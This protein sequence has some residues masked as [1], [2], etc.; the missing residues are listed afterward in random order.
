M[1]LVI[2]TNVLM[3]ALIKDA[4]T[5]K[6]IIE[7]AIEFYAPEVIKD[8]IFKYKELILKK[9]KSSEKDCIELFQHLFKHVELIPND[10]IL[11]KVAKAKEIMYGVDPNDVLFIAAALS[12]DYDGI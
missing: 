6:I 5:R 2:D 1:K 10:E 4:A 12:G 9:S 8:E 7:S 11:P 3:S